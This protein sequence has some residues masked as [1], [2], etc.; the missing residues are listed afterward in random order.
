MWTTGVFLFTDF[1][2][3][4]ANTP[5]FEVWVFTT[6]GFWILMIFLI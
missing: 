5:A 1:V 3:N 6:S 2:A 4:L